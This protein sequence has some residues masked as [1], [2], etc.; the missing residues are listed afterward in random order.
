MI[1]QVPTGNVLV[2]SYC[3][4]SIAGKGALARKN[5]SGGGLEAHP[6][7]LQEV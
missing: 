5:K 2:L 1:L 7:L 4:D 3:G 6:P